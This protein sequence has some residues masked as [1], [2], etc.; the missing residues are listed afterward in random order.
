M[1]VKIENW[2]R[3]SYEEPVSFSTHAVRLYPRTDRSITTHQ[4]ETIVNLESDIQYR[5]DLFDNIVANC[6]LPTPGQVLEIRVKLEVELWPKNPFHFLLAPRALQLPFEYTPEENRILAP[7]RTIRSEE[8]ADTGEIWRLNGNPNTVEALVELAGTLQS[9][10]AYEVRA[11]GKARLPSRT[12]ELRSGACRDTALLCATIL[13]QIGLAARVVS[14]FLC[15]FHVD[16]KDRRAESGLHAWVDVF[17]PGAGWVGIDPT[18]GTF[19]D[20]RFIPTAVGAEMTDIAPI[21]GSYFGEHHGTF[22]SHLDLSL[23]MEKDLTTIAKHVEDTLGSERVVL[24]MGGEPTFIPIKPEGPEWHFAAVGPT[25]L[26]YAHAF[27][28]KMLETVAPGALTLYSPGKLYPGEVNPRWA[29]QILHTPSQEPLG[30]TDNRRESRLDGKALKSI[31]DQLLLELEVEDRWLQAKDPRAPGSPVWVLPLDHK[32]GKWI[33]ERWNIRKVELLPAEGPTGLRLPLNRLPEDAIKRALV[34]ETGKEGLVIFLPPLLIEQWERLVRVIAATVGDRYAVEWQGYLPVDLPST[35]TRLGFTADP[36][37][38]EV[39][40]PVCKSWLEYQKWILALEERAETIGLRSFREEP[41]PA[42]TGGGSHLLFGGFS[43]EENPFFT[44]PAWLASILRYWQHHPSLSYLFTGRY[45]G[46][47]SQAPRPDESGNTLLD[48]ELAYRQLEDL[49]AGDSRLQIN[50]LVRHLHTDVAG[51]THRS[52]TSFDKFWSPPTGCYG[53]IEFRAVESFPKADWTGA[54]ALLWRALLAYFL[55]QPFRTALKD[56]GFDLHDKFFLPTPLWEDLTHVLSELA[57]FGFGF[58]PAVFRQIWEWRFPTMLDQEGLTIRNAL[59]GWPLLAETPALGGNT[60]RFVDTSIERLELAASSS[61]YQQYALFVNGRELPFRSISSKESIAGL[62]Y[63]KSA[64]YPSLHPLIGVQLP[65][66]IVL[67]ERESDTVHKLFK[68][69]A[70]AEKFV[71]EPPGEFQR[72]KPCEPPTPGMYTC[73][74][75]IE[76]AAYVR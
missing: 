53:L 8:E 7:F 23:L 32:D 74:L 28:E 66:S 19:C 68:L 73:D 72:G 46:I 63:R 65:L 13:R 17:L 48:L 64:L 26:A 35:W 25:K 47:S 24:T 57:Q 27:A 20:H 69:T 75:R 14:G 67:L 56:F 10:I 43:I 18:N 21:Q 45:V 39:N 52:E 30:H 33:T 42:G 50:E 71:E 1:R 70:E 3:Y 34:I 36:G 54:V 16:V 59:E 60:S 22:D 44:R 31:R 5:R 41:L 2:M 9:E 4:L 6:F 76:T 37:V 38:L 61:F 62:R 51:N 55:K 40:L 11:E 58:D 29:L 15:E 49:P 12:I